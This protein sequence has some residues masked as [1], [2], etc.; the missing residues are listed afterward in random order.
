MK[1]SIKKIA[2]ATLLTVSTGALAEISVITHPS[3]S[4]SLDAKSISKIFLGKSKKFASGGQAVP[5][6]QAEGSAARDEFHINVTRKK[7]SQLQSYWSRIVFT[8]KGQPP[9]EV[10]SD[11]EVIALVAKNPNM[12][13]YVNSSSVDGS[14]KVVLTAP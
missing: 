12:I 2:I 10:A 4:A 13:G 3:N 1:S 5:I 8:G 6:D 7:S 9:K 11:A 14:V